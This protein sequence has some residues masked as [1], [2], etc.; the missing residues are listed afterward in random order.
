[1]YIR[2]LSMHCY[3]IIH[4]TPHT[5]ENPATSATSAT[6]KSNTSVNLLFLRNMHFATSATDNPSTN[7]IT[8]DPPYPRKPCYFCYFCYRQVN[9]KRK[10]VV[11]TEHA[12]CYFSYRQSKHKHYQIRPPVPSKILLLL[13]LLLPTSQTQGYFFFFT[14]H[15]F[16]WDIT[17]TEVVLP[18]LSIKN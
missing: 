1:M 13:L 16:C 6:D 14:K 12:F 7:I 4:P 15:A 18:L 11:F 8:S 5:P 9:H 17:L 3:L 2:C 10:F